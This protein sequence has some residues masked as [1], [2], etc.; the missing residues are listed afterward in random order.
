MQDNL[1]SALSDSQIAKNGWQSLIVDIDHIAIAVEDL[2]TAIHW[3][4]TCLGFTLVDERETRGLNT[5][6]KSAVLIAGRAVV[7]LVQGTSAESQVSRFVSKFGAGVQ[8]IAFEVSDV[9]DALARVVR[10]GGSAD[11]KMIVDEG[12]RQIFL[13]RESGSGVRVELIEKRGGSFTDT[14][15]QKIFLQ[16]EEHDL[17]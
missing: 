1:D 2:S 16:F 12:I 13:R 7:V 10:Q 14:S 9:D 3:Y 8:H 4:V 6:M 15:V 5:G 11:T 17:Y